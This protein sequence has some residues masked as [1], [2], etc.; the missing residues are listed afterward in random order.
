MLGSARMLKTSRRACF[1][2]F[3]RLYGVSNAQYLTSALHA[4]HCSELRQ[5]MAEPHWRRHKSCRLLQIPCH[6]VQHDKCG[7]TLPKHRAYVDTAASILQ[8]CE[9]VSNG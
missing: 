8:V 7:T 2:H 1:L 5:S 6:V 4:V 3:V 9:A